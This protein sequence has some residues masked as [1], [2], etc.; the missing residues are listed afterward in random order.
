MTK[1]LGAIHQI[2]NKTIDQTNKSEMQELSAFYQ[3]YYDKSIKLYDNL[4]MTKILN[5]KKSIS[6]YDSTGYIEEFIDL[7]YNKLQKRL[8]EIK[9]SNE[10]D[11]GFYPGRYN[12]IHSF[13]YSSIGK[14]LI[15]EMS[16]M[17]VFC[18]LYIMD[19]ERVHKTRDIIIGSKFGKE[20]MKYKI[21]A[22]FMSG[23]V[24]S[25][26][27]CVITFVSFFKYVSFDGLWN[28]PISSSMVAEERYMKMFYNV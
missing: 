16:L 3:D 6:G 24:F 26:V 9:V 8:D 7:N 1:E 12:K 10:Y 17:M 28:V 21:I 20:T 25:I 4:D 11:Y 19:Y 18:M 2:I 14:K 5:T 23:L 22:G 15:I 27:L 13:L